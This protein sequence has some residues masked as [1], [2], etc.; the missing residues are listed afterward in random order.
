MGIRP[1][2]ERII[3]FGNERLAT[4]VSSTAPTLQKLLDAGYDVAA[5]VL[6]NE[7]TASRNIRKL[8]IAELAEQKSIPVLTPSKLSE[9]L[10]ELKKYDAS[11]GVLVAYGKI[12]PQSVI[13]AFPAGIVNI[14]PSLL[15]L[16]RGPTPLESVIL[17]GEPRTGVSLMQLAKEMDAGRVYAYSAIDLDGTES[18]QFLADELLE[19]GS[20]MLLATLPRIISGE[21]VGAPQDDALA[22]F[23]KLIAKEDSIINWQK[24]AEQLAREVRA[25][26]TWPQ[27]RTILGDHAVIVTQVHAEAGEGSP[28][29]VWRSGKALG[30]YTGKGILMIDKLKPAG[31]AEMAIEAFLNGYGKSL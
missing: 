2:R 14:H 31:K 23:D 17:N 1:V 10:P 6:K 18:K 4:G 8:E 3:F 28:G 20:E 15:P 9:I 25:Y 26:F 13:D 5:I 12:V 21:I 30:V 7:P 11:A 29:E 24:P 22:T 27:S 16:H 19:I